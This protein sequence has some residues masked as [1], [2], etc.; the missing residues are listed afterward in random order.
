MTTGRINQITI[1]WVDTMVGEDLDTSQALRPL[2]VRH[3][4]VKSAGCS[5]EST[6]HSLTAESDSHLEILIQ[7][8]PG[9]R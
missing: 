3:A 9:C 6:A 7:R 8:Q 4:I 2:R 1:V 5:G